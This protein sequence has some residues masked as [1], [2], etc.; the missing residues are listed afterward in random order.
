LVNALTALGFGI[1]IVGYFWVIEHFSVNV[2]VNDQLSDVSVIRAAQSHFIPWEALWVQHNENRM[3][4]PNAIVVVLAHTVHFNIRVEEWLSGIMLLVATALLIWA[5][6]SRSPQTPWL[7]YCPVAFLTFSLVQY[8]NTLLG[9]QMAWYLVL[10]CLA[11]AVV[12]LDRVTLTPIVLIA[13]IAAGVVGSFSSLQGLF[14]WPVGLVLLYHRRRSLAPFIAWTVSAAITAAVYFHNFN[15][16]A[17]NPDSGY[18]VHHPL[19]SLKFFLFAIGD[20]VGITVKVGGGDS[21]VVFFGAVIVLLAAFVLIRYGIRR[22][23]E[24]GGPVG[25]ALIVFGVMFAASIV[26]GRGFFGYWGASASRYTTYDLVILVG[27]Y[28]A[29]VGRP[30]LRAMPTNSSEPTEID[31]NPPS[32]RDRVQGALVAGTLSLVRGVVAVVIVVQILLG[33]QDGIQKVRATHK[34]QIAAVEVSHDLKHSSN[35]FLIY[36]IDPGGFGSSAQGPYIRTQLETAEN[37]HLSLYAGLK[38]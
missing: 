25:V 30:T 6:K 3:F 1:P 23:E 14:I 2:I 22:D 26:Q 12:L 38:R 8:G 24:G 4:F 10:L 15:S 7:Y 11:V 33:L 18:A 21:N 5:H 37:L 29:I 32:R 13:A 31:R 27:I 19:A 17:A 34:S 16:S 36:F 9:F 35:D 20:I 28:L